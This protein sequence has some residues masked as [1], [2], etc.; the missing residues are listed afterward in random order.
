[1]L[2]HHMLSTYKSSLLLLTCCGTGSWLDRSPEMYIRWYNMLYI[3]NPTENTIFSSLNYEILRLEIFKKTF[4]ISMKNVKSHHFS[5]RCYYFFLPSSLYL[6]SLLHLKC[7]VISLISNV[8]NF[9]D[10]QNILIKYTQMINYHKLF[11][12]AQ[13]IRRS[14]NLISFH[15]IQ[16]PISITKSYLRLVNCVWNIMLL[17]ISVHFEL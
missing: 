7:S 12:F 4:I 14:S 13:N 10:K 6:F 5:K 3:T 16:H 8:Y 15:F 17:E 2:Y 9:Y 11:W 1:M